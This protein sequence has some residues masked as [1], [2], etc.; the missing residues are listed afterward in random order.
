MSAILREVVRQNRVT[1]GIVYL[2]VSRGAAWRDHGFPADTAP[3]LVVTARSQAPKAAARNDGVRV[4]SRPDIRWKRV[5]IK[6]VGLL[7][8][9][10]AKQAAVRAGAYECW[11]VDDDGFVTEGTATNAWIV[12]D[13]KELIT[14][15]PSHSILNGI[16]R[17]SVLEVARAANYR[18]VERAFSLEEALIAPE[19]FLTSTTSWVMP[20]IQIDDTTIGDGKPGELTRLLQAGYDAYMASL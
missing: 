6:T 14:R 17:R 2:Q 1:H 19:A 4:I 13:S 12:T 15:E 20:I 5:D 18:I 11:M 16:T 3:A 10:L 9:V 7:P 8:N